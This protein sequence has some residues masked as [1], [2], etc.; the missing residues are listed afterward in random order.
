MQERKYRKVR[1]SKWKYRT[2]VIKHSS[3]KGEL[4]IGSRTAL[5]K[6]ESDMG[7]KLEFIK[8]DHTKTQWVWCL[9]R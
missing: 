6:I 8:T 7:H 1:M 3:K 2:R 4:V 5:A 9:A